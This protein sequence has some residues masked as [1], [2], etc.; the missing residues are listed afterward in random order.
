MYIIFIVYVVSTVESFL[1][2]EDLIQKQGK[3]DIF[4]VLI[5][6][7]PVLNTAFILHCIGKKL[8][9]TLSKTPREKRRAFPNRIF[10]INKNKER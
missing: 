6:L 5:V 10:G 3:A 8:F 9:N 2:M 4:D 1:I 7:T